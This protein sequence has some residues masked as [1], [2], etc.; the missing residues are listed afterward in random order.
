MSGRTRVKICGVRDEEIALAAVECGA[1]ALGFV[2]SEGSPRCLSPERAYE[3]ACFLPPFVAKVALVVNPEPDGLAALGR[4][5]PYDVV[6]LHGTETEDLVRG[7]REACGAPLIKAIRFEEATIGD[8]LARWGEVE[9]IDALLVD[10][11]TGGRGRAFD[12]GALAEVQG[13]CPHPILLAGGLTH[14]TVGQAIHLVGPYGV[15]VS[16]G[17]ER[18]RGV[19]DAGL[20]AVFCDAVREADGSA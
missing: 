16:S 11:S 17:V 18:S 10:G 2:F 15:D 19:K 12:W 4:V 1:D 13:T 9:E 5:F 7:C 8:E 3:I 20:I 6:Q 14:E